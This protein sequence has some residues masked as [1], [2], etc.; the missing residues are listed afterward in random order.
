MNSSVYIYG[1]LS[2]GYTQY[3]D[4]DHSSAIFQKFYTQS[5]STTQIAIYRDGNLMYYAYLRKLEHNKYI[6]L[7]VLLNGIMITRFE[8][9]FSLFEGV[10]SNLVTNGYL[11]KFDERGN[12]TANTNKLYMNH[13][14]IDLVTT[15]LK[16]GFNNL[17]ASAKRL[18]PINYAVNNT[19][20][21][22]FSV[23]D[24]EDDILQ[25]SYTNGYTYI[26]KSKNYNTA[27]I[28]SYRG[29]L[30]RVSKQNDQLKKENA[31]LIASNEKIKKQKKQYQFII[32]L[33]I[34]VIGCCCGLFF[35]NDNLNT[36]KNELADANNTI[37][38]KNQNI[39]DQRNKISNMTSQI[40][41]LQ[42]SLSDEKE[43]RESAENEMKEFKSLVS[44]SIPII[45]TDIEIANVYQ[46]GDIQTSYGGSIYSSNSMYLQP[47]ITYT[48]IREGESITL[49]AKLYGISGTLQT[50]S[51]SPSGYTF[52][53]SMT[54]FSGSDN[55][56]VLSGWGS[57]SK[58]FWSSGS[59]RYEIWY[60]NVCLKAKT[61][62]IY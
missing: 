59:Y 17:E 25:S 54:I 11:I 56:H 4:E 8:S 24:S 37:E 26:Y 32:V 55:T 27:A 5:K 28:D 20:V 3:P 29:V 7:C 12:L 36:T 52:S 38:E 21:K 9:L 31:D 16:A 30:S 15:S 39:A 62:T 19:S 46:N 23:E 51:S 34:A 33:F 57:A 1:D 50:G 44:S 41:S 13:E 22:N 47:R 48:G 14:E 6:G 61:F 42:S 53:S 60:G 40:N 49:Y 35:L 18:P 58:G 43:K 10:I 2:N 45:I